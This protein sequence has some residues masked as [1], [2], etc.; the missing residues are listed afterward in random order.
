LSNRVREAFKKAHIHVNMLR[1]MELYEHL[2]SNMSWLLDVLSDLIRFD[3]VA[4]PGDDY[5]PI[6]DYLI[7]VFDEL[8]FETEKIVMPPEL[9]E[10]RCDVPGLVGDRVNF[11]ARLDTG[12]EE[13]LVIYTHLDVVP[14]GTG[15]FTDP[16]DLT[17]KKDRVYGRG[18][19][20]S[21]GAVACLISALDAVQACGSHRYNLEIVLTTDE[22][23]AGYSGL[24][25]FADS[26]L[27]EGDY[28]LCMDSFSD[29]LIIGCNGTMTWQATVQG[30]SVH[31]GASF[32]GVNAIEKSFPVIEA[33]LAHKK[34]VESR[35]SSIPASSELAEF[36]VTKMRPMLN[37]TIIEGGV[38]ENIVPEKCVIRGDR[39]VIPDERME[40]AV[41][42][43]ERVFESLDLG[44]G[45]KLEWRFWMGY[46]PMRIDPGHPWVSR[47][48]DALETATGSKPKLSGAQYSLDL[49]YVVNVTEIPSCAYG[50]GRQTDS[51]PHGANENVTLVDLKH[52]ARFL[53]A[54]LTTP[55]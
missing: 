33:I 52:Y 25:Y 26:G 53:V 3:T 50:V 43:I 36:G 28:M 55:R 23:V 20:D 49:S 5:H 11:K 21:K 2:D 27:I 16:F 46:P 40:D 31:S 7:D 10:Q 32:L 4:P 15:W 22:E 6:V 42:E 41:A 30:R 12:A 38:K 44:E 37:I 47:V 51:N 24:C 18:T 14:A 19:A 8:G 13:T 17:T 1:F 34:E 39:R 29:D 35:E 9:F 54:L 48:A 45:P